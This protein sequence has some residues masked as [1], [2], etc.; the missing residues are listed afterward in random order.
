MNEQL[1]FQRP[2]WSEYYAFEKKLQEIINDLLELKKFL[3]KDRHL[4]S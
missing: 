2:S 1:E 4:N 3:A